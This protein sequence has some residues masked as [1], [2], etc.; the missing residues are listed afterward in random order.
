MKILSC[1]NIFAKY[2][3]LLFHGNGKNKIAHP[4]GLEKQ[5]RRRWCKRN[6]ISGKIRQKS[7]GKRGKIFL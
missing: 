2:I 6:D 5:N 1:Y 3:I 4:A 7:C